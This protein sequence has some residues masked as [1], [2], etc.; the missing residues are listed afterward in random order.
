[1]R[2]RVTELC[3]DAFIFVS[4]TNLSYTVARFTCDT[5]LRQAAVKNHGH[6]SHCMML[7]L[8]NQ[9]RRHCSILVELD[10]KR[11]W[12][13]RLALPG[14]KPARRARCSSAALGHWI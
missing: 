7:H 9:L 8:C 1:M 10:R 11:R 2:E 12:R 14:P 4:A 5:N 3:G 6:F 13:Q